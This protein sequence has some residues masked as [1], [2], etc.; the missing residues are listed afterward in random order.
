M[1]K[2]MACHLMPLATDES[3][4]VRSLL[5]WHPNTPADV[6]N[7]MMSEQDEGVRNSLIKR[8]FFPRDAIVSYYLNQKLTNDSF[9]GSVTIERGIINNLTHSSN[10]YI[11]GMVARHMWCKARNRKKLVQEDHWFIH[12][13]AKKSTKK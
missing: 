8:S 12:A 1:I 5:A 2:K 4:D 10:T 6:L 9:Y 13:M 11:R 7:C 3:M